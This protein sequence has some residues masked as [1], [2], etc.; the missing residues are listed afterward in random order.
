MAS[1]QKEESNFYIDPLLMDYFEEFS[2]EGLLRG[3]SVDFEAA[4]IETA[5]VDLDG[6]I[7]A[8][9]SHSQESPNLL[10]LDFDVWN[11]YSEMERTFLI[12]HEL[13]HCYLGRD[14]DDS[15]DSEGNCLSIMHSGSSICNNTFESNRA[16]LLDELFK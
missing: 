11:Q 5:F 15:K 14:H 2:E 12:F 7:A 16:T 4:E 8:Q 13:G 10:R 6:A 3:V 9:C 1:C